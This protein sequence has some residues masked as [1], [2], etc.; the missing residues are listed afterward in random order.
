LRD[1]EASEKREEREK[2]EKAQRRRASWVSES[3]GVSRGSDRTSC[4]ALR[5]SLEYLQISA[6]VRTSSSELYESNLPET[7]LHRLE[8]DRADS[9]ESAAGRLRGSEELHNDCKIA[10]LAEK[11]S[12]NA[13]LFAPQS[14]PSTFHLCGVGL[15][16]YIL[17]RRSG[18]QELRMTFS[19]LLEIV[20][21]MHL[22]L[23][24]SSSPPLAPDLSPFFVSLCFF[25][26]A[27][28]LFLAVPGYYMELEKDAV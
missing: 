25:D 3:K 18:G 2:K 22:L 21:F 9:T 13:L 1:E 24:P 27:P 14:A 17:Y 12:E 7:E 16:C 4:R 5:T 6:A 10:S 11:R 28:L 20:D 23:S 26:S 19:R 8:A 15:L